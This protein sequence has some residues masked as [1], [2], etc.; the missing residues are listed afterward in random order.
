MIELA[1]AW[2]YR[3]KVQQITPKQ[4]LDQATRLRLILHREFLTLCEG[5]GACEGF[6][7][8]RRLTKLRFYA[9]RLVSVSTPDQ[10]NEISNKSSE[11]PELFFYTLVLRTVATQNLDDVLALG[12]NA[13]QAAAQPLRAADAEAVSS[14]VDFRNATAE[15]QSLAV[16][17]LNGVK[18][19]RPV[20]LTIP[21]SDLIRFAETGTEPSMMKSPDTFFREVACLHGLTDKPRHSGMLEQAFDEDEALAMDAIEQLH[22]SVSLG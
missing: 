4:L 19:R 9:S 1:Q 12:T 17:L 2:W 15:E 11:L 7:R 20:P 14:A 16:L 22:Q 18:I 5:A 6:E 8:K 3:R 13:A 21:E 10:L